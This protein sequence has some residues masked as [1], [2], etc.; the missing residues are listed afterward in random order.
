MI[1]YPVEITDEI[2]EKY[3]DIDQAELESEIYNTS[4]DV[5]RYT[6]AV[7]MDRAVAEVN[8][9]P[10]G[11]IAFFRQ[12]AAE[13]SLKECVALLMFLER[14]NEA[15]PPE[16]EPEVEAETFSE[17]LYQAEDEVYIREGARGKIY[18]ATIVSDVKMGD[19]TATVDWGGEELMLPL[20][21]IR[22]I[23]EACWINK[24]KE[25]VQ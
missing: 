4:A 7:D 16:P 2:L 22:G 24:R 15:R 14:L 10:K 19:T 6:A 25:K 12:G 3:A 21:R 17:L 20:T 23:T 5:K 1:N 18:H 8:I 13:T 11:K 9:G